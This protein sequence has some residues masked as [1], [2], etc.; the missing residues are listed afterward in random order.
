MSLYEWPRR[1]QT[2]NDSKHNEIEGRLAVARRVLERNAPTRRRSQRA[3]ANA[4]ALL[5]EGAAGTDRA[6]VASLERVETWAAAA[7]VLEELE[8]LREIVRVP[9]T[10]TSAEARAA[11]LDDL[12]RAAEGAFYELSRT[13]NHC[14]DR[15]LLIADLR[16]ALAEFGRGPGV[17]E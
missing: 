15:E 16:A 8:D 1:F 5:I 11:L 6:V 7:L 10:V 13:G 4:N 14:A 17:P 2:E 3:R 12:L 9:A